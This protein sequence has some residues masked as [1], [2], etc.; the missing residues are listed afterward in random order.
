MT[1]KVRT[2]CIGFE[3]DSWMCLRFLKI[4]SIEVELDGCDWLNY[5][6]GQDLMVQNKMHIGF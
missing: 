4:F 6:Y 2:G 3:K 5:F 1:S